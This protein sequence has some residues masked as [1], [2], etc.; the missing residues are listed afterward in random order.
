MAAK[1]RG[2]KALVGVGATLL[3]GALAWHLVAAPALVRFPTDL[4][5][6]VRF[7]GTVKL[8]ADPLTAM[9]LADPK[10]FPMTIDQHIRTVPS[11]GDGRS[12][13]VDVTVI[14]KAAPIIDSTQEHRYVIDRSSMANVDDPRAFAFG[15]G[16]P[17]DR[18]GS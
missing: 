10:S 18:S 1:R 8:L 16:H 7:E 11:A 3:A 15:A 4:D 5:K 6:N 17:V 12:T 9:Q 13:V 14:E 2:A